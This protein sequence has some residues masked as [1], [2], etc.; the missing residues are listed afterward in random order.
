MFLAP[1]YKLLKTRHPHISVVGFADDTNL[2][3]FGKTQD[4][5]IR[6]LQEAWKTCKDWAEK[7]GIRF[8]PEKSELLHFQKPARGRKAQG[9][10]KKGI[11]LSPGSEILP[12]EEARF[13]GV[14]LDR[15]LTWQ[16]HY[17]SRKRKLKTQT[18]ALT[19]LAGKTWGPDLQKA[20]L[21]YL[22]VIRTAIAYG[23]T[24]CHTPSPKAPATATRV[25]KPTGYAKALE[26]TQN[27]CLRVVS[28]A[29]KATPTYLL[30]VETKTPPLDLYLN[31]HRAKFERR[32]KA[33]P[34][35]KVIE[36]AERRVRSRFDP[37]GRNRK[38]RK[39]DK[40]KKTLEEWAG[41][42]P[43]KDLEETLWEEWGQRIKIKEKE[44]R[45]RGVEVGLERGG[46]ACFRA[47]K[48]WIALK[49]YVQRHDGLRKAESSALIQ[50]RTGKIGLKAFLFQ[51]K[52]PGIP[53]PLCDCGGA[54]ETVGHLLEGCEAH[55]PPQGL[56]T[57]RISKQG[58]ARGENVR[59]IL[60]WLMGKL[61]EYKVALE[62][63]KEDEDD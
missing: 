57:P 45:E 54:P 39:L 59:P 27:D 29:Y 9:V 21:L 60:R 42:N 52:V 15:G 6:G 61:P 34:V 25:T 26:K 33:T 1:L 14:W 46:I 51:R 58:I 10:W 62:L 38:R 28:G 5:T 16:A 17:Q 40:D 7:Q 8:S 19:R 47:Q 43:R 53:T 23:A 44:R 4:S 11:E 32:T 35:G 56:G 22:V 31:Y 41:E 48:P 2:L 37:L 20:R 49:K 13:L 18:L 30:E 55:E 12:K 50:A 36:E 3:A 63:E 24:Y